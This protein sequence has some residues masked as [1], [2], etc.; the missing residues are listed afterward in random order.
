[1]QRFLL[2][3]DFQPQEDFLPNE[4][5]QLGNLLKDRL[6]LT[7]SGQFDVLQCLRGFLGLLMV[8]FGQ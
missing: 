8:E 2:A 1:M 6:L 7:K 5:F 3:V 4:L